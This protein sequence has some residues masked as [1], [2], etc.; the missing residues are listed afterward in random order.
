MG[1]RCTCSRV[2]TTRRGVAC[3]GGECFGAA[4]GGFLRLS[5]AQ[6]DDRLTEAVVFIAEATTRRERMA[7]YLRSHPQYRLGTP[8]AV[9]PPA[10]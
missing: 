8:Y 5:C 2:R 4:G 9:G 10:S 6:P 7:A 1:W 3:L